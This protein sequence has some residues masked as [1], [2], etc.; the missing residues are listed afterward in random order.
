MKRHCLYQILEY[1]FAQSSR[2]STRKL[3][4]Y[5]LLLYSSKVHVWCTFENKNDKIRNISQF[6]RCQKFEFATSFRKLFE[7]AIF[8]VK[9]VFEN[10]F[11][12]LTW[13][14]M[15]LES[16][17]NDLKNHY[18]RDLRIQ[19]IRIERLQKSLQSRH[20]TDDCFH[21]KSTIASIFFSMIFLIVWTSH[22][23]CKIFAAKTTIDNDVSLIAFVEISMIL[24]SEISCELFRFERWF[25]CERFNQIKLLRNE[26]F[27]KHCKN[28]F[29]RR[30]KTWLFRQLLCFFMR[31]SDNSLAWNQKIKSIETFVLVTC[32]ASK[33]RMFRSH[34]HVFRIRKDEKA[35]LLSRLHVVK[36]NETEKSIL[37]F[38][39][40][41]IILI[42]YIITYKFKLFVR[43][44]LCKRISETKQNDVFNSLLQ[45]RVTIIFCFKRNLLHVAIM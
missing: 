13:F 16:H 19:Q 20:Q 40:C 33:N 5:S 26:C 6:S 21:L 32:T 2:K 25:S 38:M 12:S 1:V 10:V 8:F 34:L 27:Q 7:F 41:M 31:N 15:L 4:H 44:L 30:L 14:C 29:R 18:D 43:N 24:W 23:F 17:R 35:F 9:F 22:S 45:R 39:K 11:V 3:L 37:R 36:K 42:E 28:T